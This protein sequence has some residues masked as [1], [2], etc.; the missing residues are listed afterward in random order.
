MH[1]DALYCEVALHTVQVVHLALRFEEQG[2]KKL[3]PKLHD[4]DFM[5]VQFLHTVS[6]V[7]ARPPRHAGHNP[8]HL[9][10]CT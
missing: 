1:P 3:W 6:C 2:S 5:T 10:A 9:D 7:P 8:T 4:E